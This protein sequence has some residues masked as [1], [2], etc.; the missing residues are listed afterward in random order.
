VDGPAT[1]SAAESAGCP[2]RRH[3][4]AQLGLAVLVG[5]PVVAAASCGREGDA[6][7]QREA[8]SSRLT[9]HQEQDGCRQ[10]S[11]PPATKPEL[12]ADTIAKQAAAREQL[13]IHA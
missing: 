8:A 11:H 1:P 12:P 4:S 13:T 3:A 2:P 6:Q 9:N 10:A 7:E 5:R